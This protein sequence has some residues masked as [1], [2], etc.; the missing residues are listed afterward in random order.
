M[1]TKK[2]KN[3]IKTLRKDKERKNNTLEINKKTEGK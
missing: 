2:V 1:K 3:N